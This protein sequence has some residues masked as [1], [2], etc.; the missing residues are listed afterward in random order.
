MLIKANING[1]TMKKILAITLLTLSQATLADWTLNNEQ[2]SLN[3]ISTKNATVTEVHHFKSLQGNLT[4]AGE[5]SISVDLNSVETNVSIRN[6]RMNEFLFNTVK[7][8]KATVNLTIN[9]AKI[10]KLSVG[11]STKIAVAAMV[12]LHGVV[13]EITT[14]LN[15]VALKNGGLQASS[16]EP[17]ILTPAKFDLLAGIQKLQELAKLNSITTTVPI[18]FNF[19]FDKVL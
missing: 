9:R 10:S 12:S 6:K 19:V 8:P 11:E 13:Q 17:I 4:D 3:F 1:V 2:S 18:S 16:L 15:V 7:F 5:A 14:T